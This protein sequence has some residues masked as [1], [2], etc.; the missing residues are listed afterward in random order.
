[1]RLYVTST[2]SGTNGR[3]ELE[4]LCELVEKAGWDTFC[5]KRDIEQ[6]D[7][8]FRDQRTLRVRTL[9][10]MRRCDALLVDVSHDAAAAAIEAGMAYAC[11][12]RI[13]LLAENGR[14]PAESMRSI[15]DAVIE[16]GTIDDIQPELV[17]LYDKWA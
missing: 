14:P 5:F 13:I 3:T 1:M 7:D 11:G 8:I 15:A 16:Y 17:R 9:L 10:E 6:W 2:N 4:R 12:K